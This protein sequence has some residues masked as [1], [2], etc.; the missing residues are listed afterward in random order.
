MGSNE[1][2]EIT[3]AISSHGTTAERFFIVPDVD[4]NKAGDTKAR[5]KLEALTAAGLKAYIYPLP[6]G[7]HDVND[8]QI[9]AAPELYDW[10]REA[11]NFAA[12]IEAEQ[13]AEYN[14]RS[15]A[16]LLDRFIEQWEAG[17]NTATPTGFSSLDKILDGGLFPGLYSIGAISSLGKT[18]FALQ[19]ADSIAAAGRDVLYFS[20][21]QSAA[22]LTAKTLSRLTALI[23]QERTKD[24]QDALSTWDISCKSKRDFWKQTTRRQTVE[25]AARR[26]RAAIGPRL[27]I[28][29]GVGDISADQIRQAVALHINRRG[30]APVVYIDYVQILDAY[31]EHLTDKQN[32]DRNIVELK[33]ISRDF[34]TAIVAI[35]SFNRTSYTAKADLEAFKESGAVEYTSDCVIGIHPQGLK[36][37]E[38]EKVGAENRQIIRECK[39]AALRKL[40]AV[41]LKNRNGGTGTVLLEYL[42]PY[43]LY[44]DRG[45]K[46][47]RKD[48]EQQTGKGL[49][50]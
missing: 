36:D 33:R 25:E 2:A 44:T 4:E 7:F 46:P 6:A 38:R 23:S 17:R 32:M 24:Y 41:V 39:G 11:P 26:Y 10:I 14:A 18:T 3:D 37:G 28:V 19:M 30:A 48:T 15:G 35:S 20:L 42:T 16:A 34:N 29:E 1:A 45:I 12:A 21:E 31:G 49:K 47:K 27:F 22:E 43:N 50:F 13:Q 9:K 8:L 40:E 5:K